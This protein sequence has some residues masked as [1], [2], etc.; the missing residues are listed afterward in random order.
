MIDSQTQKP[1]KVTTSETA[2]SYIMVS[3]DQLA[4]VRER[5][6]QHKISY[7]ADSHAISLDDKPAIVFINLG[8][9]E[10]AKR[11]QEILDDDA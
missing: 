1:V 2:G 11:V 9:S 7:W 8:L 3:L 5:L 4:R 6:D 10:D